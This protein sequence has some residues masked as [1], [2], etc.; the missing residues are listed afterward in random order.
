[1]KKP[2]SRAA[3]VLA[4]LACCAGTAR[5]GTLDLTAGVLAFN[6]FLNVAN[7][8]TI[9]P[10][11]GIYLVTDPAEAIVLSANALQEGC[12]LV[13]ATTASC[14]S[15]AIVSLMIR[16]GPGQDFV[17]LT[18]VGAPADIDGGFD[19]DVIVGSD[20]DDTLRWNP[21]GAS[22]TIHGG[23][24]ND[25][26]LFTG[27]NIGET[28]AVSEDGDGFDIF[29]NIGN[30]TLDADDVEA[31]ELVT[32]GGVDDI[33]TV[34]LRHTTQS[35]TAGAEPAGSP[36]TLTI[37]GGGVCLRQRGSTFEIEGRPTIAFA[38]FDIVIPDDFFCRADA[39]AGAVPTVGC[40]VN[41][42]RD[43]ICRG[44]DGNDVITGTKDGDVILGGDGAD[45]IRGGAGDDLVCG[46]GGDDALVGARGNDTIFGGPGLDTIRG[47][48]GNDT[49]VGGDDVDNLIGGSGDDELDGNLGDDRLR[50]GAGADRLRGGDGIDLVDGA[51]GVDTCT[52]TDQV[53]L[54][55]RCELP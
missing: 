24:G 23:L 17:T 6:S 14:P 19:G 46:E 51:G 2:F 44:T 37:L 34:P 41:G 18:G 10:V 53:G 13:D 16:P 43:Q 55:L 26:L 39:C 15:A 25:T 38:D 9:E 47:D 36:D 7:T 1:M 49:L 54:I 52:D 30:V 21:G 8:L 40:T 33:F 22:D 35:L 12:E 42:V 29:R 45:R 4:G 50:A 31:L 5:A 27:S 48:S 3:V 20:G 11:A 28:I 32:L